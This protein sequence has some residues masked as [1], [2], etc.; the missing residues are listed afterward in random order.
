[1][2]HK[3][4]HH[5]NSV[6]GTA[7]Y[8]CTCECS[9]TSKTYPWS[10]EGSALEAQ[11]H[12]EAEIEKLASLE[13]PSMKMASE[14]NSVIK[15]C[16]I[17]KP[18]KIDSDHLIIQD[19][20][21]VGGSEGITFE[22]GSATNNEDAPISNPKN[23]EVSLADQVR[24]ELISLV[25]RDGYVRGYLRCAECGCPFTRMDTETNERQWADHM[26]SNH[27]SLVTAIIASLNINKNGDQQ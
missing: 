18:I 20:H 15:N 14:V 10:K 6:A 26:M 23:G 27:P 11:H 9:W 3:I 12:L 25:H 8:T 1:M 4:T 13:N 24:A 19:C 2:P 7:Y 17:D 5:Y 22:R 21:V 16:Y